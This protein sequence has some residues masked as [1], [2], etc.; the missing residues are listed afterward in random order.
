MFGSKSSGP[1]LWV[2]L[3]LEFSSSNSSG[4]VGW[5]AK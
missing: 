5:T 1:A 2:G 4:E 3:S